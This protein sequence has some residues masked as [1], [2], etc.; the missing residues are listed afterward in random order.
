MGDKYTW[1]GIRSGRQEVV[2]RAQS[3]RLSLSPLSFAHFFI[4]QVFRSVGGFSWDIRKR[5]FIFISIL[6]LSAEYSILGSILIL[7]VYTTLTPPI[8]IIRAERRAT[9]RS[10]THAL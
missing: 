8:G 5:L 9:L 7:A 4:C 1:I 3:P 10:L 2:H 6:V